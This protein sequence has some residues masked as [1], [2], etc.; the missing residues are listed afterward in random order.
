MSELAPSREVIETTGWEWMGG[1][2]INEGA[3]GFTSLS[4][5]EELP[6]EAAGLNW[7]FVTSPLKSWSRFSRSSV[8]LYALE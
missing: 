4:R 3:Q 8:S 1:F 5:P 7:I 2:W 6:D